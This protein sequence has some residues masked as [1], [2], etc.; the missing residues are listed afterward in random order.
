MRRAPIGLTQGLWHD[1]ARYLELLVPYPGAW[2]HGD[3][4]MRD[5]DSYYYVLGRST[6]R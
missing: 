3:F 1:E 6:I 4:A 2:H 5:A